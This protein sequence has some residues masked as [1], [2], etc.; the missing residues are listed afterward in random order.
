M[1]AYE[2]HR[3]H[4]AV[5]EAYGAHLTLRLPD[6]ELLRAMLER[7][8]SGWSLSDARSA[9]AANGW[10]FTVT[11]D[12]NGYC[13][14]STDG[15]GALCGDV[16]QLAG[17]L[18]THMRRYVGHHA[19]DLTFVHA[20]VVAHHGRAILLPGASFA[21]K[22][23]LVAALVRE[24]AA[25]YSDEFALIDH[26]GLVH[27]YLEPLSLRDPSCADPLPHPDPILREPVRVGL[28]ALTAYEHDSIWEPSV[29]TT[30]AGIVAVMAHALPA[31]Q[32]PAQTLVVLERA[33]SRA[34]VLE[35]R[36]GDA[37]GA[38]G[39]ILEAAEQAVR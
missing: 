27:Q 20:G 32:R 2:D 25:Y 9:P 28:V 12:E 22:S 31:R 24:G 15:P 26:D 19:P 14:A 10:R 35:G 11:R 8:P 13:A 7:L 3:T 30:G 33:L 34:V 39:V 17:A 23:T 5:V 36:R 21:G 37:T 1:H 29:L 18:R 6:A 38:A 16:E 4:T